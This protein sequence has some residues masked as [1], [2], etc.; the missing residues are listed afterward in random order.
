MDKKKKII[1][2]TNQITNSVNQ[3]VDSTASF[4]K[5]VVPPTLDLIDEANG[6]DTSKSEKRI[7][8]SRSK[9]IIN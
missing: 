1:R 4:I 7:R 3:I 9:E 8:K 5:S 6:I 2:R